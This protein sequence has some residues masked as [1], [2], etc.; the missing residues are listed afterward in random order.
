MREEGNN[1]RK[2]KQQLQDNEAQK[3]AFLEDFNN[4]LHRIGRCMLIVSIILLV[5]VPLS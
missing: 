4:G 1:G 2:K 3:Q 5:G